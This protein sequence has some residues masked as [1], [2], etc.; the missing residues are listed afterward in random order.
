[1]DMLRQHLENFLTQLS[2]LG[3]LDTTIERY[4]YDLKQFL[5]YI[6]NQSL[7]V[8]EFGNY[9]TLLEKE[10]KYAPKTLKRIRVILNQF[11]EYLVANKVLKPLPNPIPPVQRIQYDEFEENQFVTY[12]DFQ[13]LV[14]SIENPRK[15]SENE[16]KV[17][18]LLK[19]RNLSMLYLFYFY[20]LSLKEVVNIQMEDISFIQNTIRINSLSKYKRY[21]HLSSEHNKIILNYYY[22]IPKPVR[23]RY[24]SKDPLFV[25]VDFNRET[26]R[27]NYDTDSP[28][29]INE[30]SVQKWLKKEIKKANLRNNISA[31]DFRS[32]F[33]IRCFL[34]GKEIEEVQKTLGL[35]SKV[36]LYRYLYFAQLIDKGT[37]N[38]LRN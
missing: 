20:G 27:W 15:L 32:S 24:H 38:S 26:F 35:R 19:E 30:R 11:Y 23:P 9:L 36:G 21:L 6:H 31:Q 12:E 4:D 8:D 7:T 14:H 29:Q 10:R 16:E 37:S 34:E 33:I 13:E 25:A 22:T 17:Y 1:M 3:K 18:H 5:Q 28:K 2:F